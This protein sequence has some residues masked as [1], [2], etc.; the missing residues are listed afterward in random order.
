[1]ESTQP[2]KNKTHKCYLNLKWKNQIPGMPKY[3][4]LYIYTVYVVESVF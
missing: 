4:Y 1:M 2:Y 3:I